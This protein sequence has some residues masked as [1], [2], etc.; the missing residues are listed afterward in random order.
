[1]K[2]KASRSF[3]SAIEKAKKLAAEGPRVAAILVPTSGRL[4]Y[5]AIPGYLDKDG[6]NYRQIRLVTPDGRVWEAK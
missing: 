3:F 6:E 4:Q 1:M 2:I 5:I